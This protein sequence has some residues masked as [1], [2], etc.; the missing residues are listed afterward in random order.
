MLMSPVSQSTVTASRAALC[1]LACIGQKF[2]FCQILRARSCL[3]SMMASSY[4]FVQGSSASF[5]S[6]QV[7]SSSGGDTHTGPDAA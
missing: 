4:C 7:T 5:T 6:R 1:V 2:E 3:R